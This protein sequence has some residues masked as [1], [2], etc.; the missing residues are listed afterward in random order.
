MTEKRN[1]ELL[2]QI[3]NPKKIK[4][5]ANFFKCHDCGK[6]LLSQEESLR[7]SG[8]IDEINDKLERGEKVES[9]KVDVGQIII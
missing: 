2:L 7:I 9:G 4:L 3:G 8:I 6:E 5:Q 1:E